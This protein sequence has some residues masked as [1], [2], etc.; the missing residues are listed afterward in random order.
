MS[1]YFNDS[2]FGEIA[3]SLLSRNRSTRVRDRN[4]AIALNIILSSIDRA[5]IRQQENLAKSITDINSK[6]ETVFNN[7]KELYKLQEKNRIKFNSYNDNPE[8]YLH[9][10]AVKKFNSHSFLNKEFGGAGFNAVTKE[11]LDEDNFNKAMQ[12]YEGFRQESLDEINKIKENPAVNIATFT[13]FNEAATN[14][15]NAALAAVRDDPTKT[16]LLRKFF[17]DIFGHTYADNKPKKGSTA[18]KIAELKS[19]L[20]NAELIRQE[21]DSRVNDVLNPATQE[22]LN[23]VRTIQDNIETNDTVAYFYGTSIPV[24][25]N[26]ESKVTQLKLDKEAFTKKVNQS[27]YQITEDDIV[28]A[29]EYDVKIPG[30]GNLDK[31]RVS[32]RPILLETAAVVKNLKS[33]GI[34]PWESNLLNR[35]QKDVWYR[36]TNED[37][38]AREKASLE[39]LKIKQE[40]TSTDYDPRK[41]QEYLGG[42]LNNRLTQTLE[43]LAAQDASFGNFYN[44]MDDKDKEIFNNNI[45]TNAEII[46][47]RTKVSIDSAIGG[48][49]ETQRQG[50]YT[51]P[52][53][54]YGNFYRSEYVD[55]NVL[56]ILDK[57]VLTETDAR[58]LAF[59]MNNRKYI[60]KR[61]HEKEEI[62]LAPDEI[63]KSF[64][65]GNYLFEVENIQDEEGKPPLLKWNYRN[66]NP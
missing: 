2:R 10:E 26:F 16:S 18:W 13:K 39:L 1:D 6:Y 12:V 33:Q 55:D 14:E 4:E 9:N 53:N 23:I 7:N 36:A 42:P 59:I 20:E 17:N 28:S 5:K 22:N 44:E 48:A 40:L 66:I 11:N 21:Q 24:N 31:I 38:V 29:I 64:V 34:N 51:V 57:D 43:N 47:S 19:S 41:I 46:R 63:G 60:Q 3:R 27:D 62:T 15:Y 8:S 50:L 65:E 58:D 52:G 25:T 56:S 35:V 49:I 45:F 30:Y 37:F 32:E 61:F 54:Y